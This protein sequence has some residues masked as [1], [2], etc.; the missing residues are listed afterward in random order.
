MSTFT[1]EAYQNEYLPLGGSEVNAIVTVSSR[2]RRRA[3]PAS[4]MPREIVIVD[5]SG[6]MGAPA[7][8][9]QGRARG[10]AAWRS[11]AS[12]T[13]SLFGVIAGTDA[14]RLRVPAG[15]IARAG[16]GRRREARPSRRSP[17]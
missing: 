1:L 13:A 11:T 8:Q 12:A 15:R 7:S 16:I 17:G 6:S 2:R 5:T 4:P 9:D 3:P 10:H 14:A